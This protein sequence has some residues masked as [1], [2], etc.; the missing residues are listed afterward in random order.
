MLGLKCMHCGKEY[1]PKRMFEGCPNCKSENFTANLI[2]EFDL[3]KIKKVLNRK[4]LKGRGKLGLSKYIELLPI[5]ET[6][7]FATLGEG[8]TRLIKCEKLG[9]LLGMNNLYIKDESRNPTGTYKDRKACIGTSIALQF[10]L[11]NIV[12]GGGN[13]GTAASAYGA[14]YGLGVI[15]FETLSESKAAIL[16]TLAYGGKVIPLKKYEDRYELMKRCVD[17]YGCYPLSSYT[18]SPTGDPYSQEGV[19]T[20]A[21]EICEDLGWRVPDKVVVPT[22]QGF[23][24]YGI[25]NGFIDFYKI[26]LIESFPSMIAAE[27]SSGG[28]F[29]KTEKRDPKYI[30]TV[31]PKTT[32]ARHAVAPK[33][34]YKGFKAIID[35]DGCSVTVTDEEVVNATKLLARSEGIFS[36]TT[37]ATTIAALKKVLG[38][39][40][41]SRDE[42]VVCIIT[43]GGLKDIDIIDKVLRKVPEPIGSDWRAFETLLD[44]DYGFSF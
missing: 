19:K 40:R 39:G 16:Q 41:I 15:S 27:S 5:K 14:K 43:G 35:S 4:A 31:Q 36:S 29:T 23:C 1:P 34:S 30:K 33:G 28:S 9:Q 17:E 25:W 2:V 18:S 26:G 11:H 37:S 13:M 7:S 38:K 32:V 21:Y 12:A 10:G 6:T 42:L 24:L 3:K 44:K 22:G 20:I 8:Q